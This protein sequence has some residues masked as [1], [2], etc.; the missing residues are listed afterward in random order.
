MNEYVIKYLLG[1]GY[2][3]IS[4]DYYD[5]V[6][7]WE[8]WYKNRVDEFHQYYDSYGTKRRMFTLGMA[9]RVCEDWASN[10]YGEDDKIT[11]DKGQNKKFIEQLV[12]DLKLDKEIPKSI[13]IASYSGTCGAVIRLKNAKLL[14][15]K[16]IADKNT[17]KKLILVSAKQIIPLKV[18]NDDVVDVAI[19]SSTNVNGTSALY[20]EL[21]QLKENGYVISN[22]YLNSKTGKELVNDN[23]LQSFETGSTTPLF[24][25]LMPPKNNPIED[26]NGLGFSIYGDAIDQIKGCDIT[27]HNFMQDFVLGGKKL[28]YNKKLIKYKTVTT[29]V[30]G[31]ATTKEVPV[32][33][34]D[35][36]KQ[37]FMETGDDFNTNDD[38]KLI[39]EYNPSLRVND[40]QTGLQFALDL[41]SFKAGMGAK[42]YQFNN[43]S[44]VTATQYVGE[45]QDLVTNAKKYRNNLNIFIGNIIKACLLFGRLVYKENVTEDCTVLIDNQDG[46]MQDDETIKQS[47]REDLALGVISKVEYRMAV[48]HETEEVAK[49]MIA[50]LNE[51]NTINNVFVGEE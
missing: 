1:K 29:T 14:D 13:E 44:V 5:Y 33:P 41:L 26:N 22:I 36:A 25:L 3:N 38:K 2:K 37:Q 47:A 32:Y 17:T 4:K 30:N 19:V 48:Y 43:G 27:Y 20:I 45:R 12:I 49:Q 18:E 39:H 24:S 40:N 7:N 50:K 11:C 34:D 9:K 8:N 16:L 42:F 23:V 15:G 51:E 10:L 31:V 28:I 46:F 6:T 21:H 35:I